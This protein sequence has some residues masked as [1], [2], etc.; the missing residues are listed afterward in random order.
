MTM[1]DTALKTA[2]MIGVRDRTPLERARATYNDLADRAGKFSDTLMDYVPEQGGVDWTSLTVGL[3][4][5]TAI[6]FG[7]GLYL[8]DRTRP[9]L[10]TAR[11]RVRSAAGTLGE[12][13]PVIKNITRMDEPAGSSVETTESV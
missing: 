2:E 5:G 3:I 9:A 8:H 11:E 7:L 12:R 4:I 10:R 1:L 6:G 13:V